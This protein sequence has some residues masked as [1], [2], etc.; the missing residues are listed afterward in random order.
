M[1]PPGEAYRFRVEPFMFPP[2]ESGQNPAS[3]SAGE[4]RPT[5]MALLGLGF[6]V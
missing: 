1:F 5:G 6:R 2:R 3:A 4:V